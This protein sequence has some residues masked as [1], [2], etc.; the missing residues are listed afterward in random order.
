MNWIDIT[1]IV[2]ACF[3]ALKGYQD[4]LI[5]QVASIAGVVIGAIFAGKVATAI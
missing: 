2:I 3:F 1:T 4:G 5:K